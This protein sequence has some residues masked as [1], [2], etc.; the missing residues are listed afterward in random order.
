MDTFN[1]YYYYLS[2]TFT[3]FPLVIKIALFL[4]LIMGIFYIMSWAR[5]GALA[6]LT[7][8][9]A[10]REERIEK[11]KE[12]I[13]VILRNQEN[14][15][16]HQILAELDAKPPIKN[17]IKEHFSE[18]LVAQM[19]QPEINETNMGTIFRALRIPEYWENQIESTDVSKKWKSIRMLDSMA[20]FVAPAV[21]FK[22]AN[23]QK[24]DLGNYAKSVFAKFDSHNAFKFLEEETNT[25]FT[26]LDKMRIHNSLKKRP[27]EEVLP[28]LIN[29]AINT[30][31][32]D[33]RIFL[34]HEIGLTGI[35]E[36]MEPILE[37]YKTVKDPRVKAQIV[38]TLSILNYTPAI[39]VFIK[40]YSFRK[41]IVQE[42]IIEG[43]GYMGGKEAL[44]FLEK[45][46][47]QTNNKEMLVRILRNIYT[48]E[49]TGSETPI[50]KKLQAQNQSE[51][52]EKAFTYIE[53]QYN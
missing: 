14:L 5:I 27:A 17:W 20:P 2:S 16:E 13:F 50:F 31:N 24:K 22:K 45:T 42:G 26:Q 28:H 7:K 34:I 1:Y 43:L 53:N 51:F 38:H 41:P 18:L 33:Y 47:A 9:D 15:E 12:R 44:D 4:I 37:L 6:Y 25:Q 36:G 32:D 8:R 52:N 49:S 23:S 29:A 39:P 35:S 3:G 11:L 40:D 30:S 48:I 10:K 46:Y 21:I 19:G